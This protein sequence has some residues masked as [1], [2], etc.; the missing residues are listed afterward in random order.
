MATDKPR[1]TDVLIVPTRAA[2]EA[3]FC[4]S[5]KWITRADARGSMSKSDGCILKTTIKLS[6]K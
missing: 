6:L 2:I 4:I 5:K 1:V 3:L